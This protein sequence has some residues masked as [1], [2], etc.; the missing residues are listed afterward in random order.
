[1]FKKK[2]WGFIYKSDKSKILSVREGTIPQTTKPYRVPL[3][4]RPK[5]EAEYERLE[6]SPF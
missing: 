2:I 3:A 5:V 1:M 4:M 6:A